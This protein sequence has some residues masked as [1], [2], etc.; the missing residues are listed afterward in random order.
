[1]QNIAFRIWILAMPSQSFFSLRVS[2][3]QYTHEH[4]KLIIYPV[5]AIVEKVVLQGMC[6]IIRTFY[7]YKG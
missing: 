5:S 4:L 7:I 1:M 6:H 3:T 2:E